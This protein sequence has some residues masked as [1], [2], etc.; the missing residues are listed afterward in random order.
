MRE[1]LCNAVLLAVVCQHLWNMAKMRR[2]DNVE[3]Y[4]QFGE[5]FRQG[6]QCAAQIVAT[7]RCNAVFVELRRAQEVDGPAGA[8]CHCGAESGV[9]EAAKVVAKPDQCCHRPTRNLRSRGY[10]SK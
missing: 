1:Y 3:G 10:G 9:V 8:G 2:I 5:L 4:S 6:L 7:Y